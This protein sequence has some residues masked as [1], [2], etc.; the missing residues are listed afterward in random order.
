V[1]KASLSHA[2]LLAHPDQAAPLALVTNASTSAMDAVLQ[3]RVNNAWQ[4]LS[5]FSKKLNLTQQKYSAIENSYLTKRQ[6]SIF[7][8]CWKRA[9]SLFSQTINLRIPAE[10]RQFN[11]LDFIAQFATDI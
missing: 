2:T 7:A 4:P 8:T 10:T 6:K 11:H 9:T 3:Q 1:C 5:F